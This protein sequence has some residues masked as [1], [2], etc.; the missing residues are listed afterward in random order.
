MLG[1]GENMWRR[2]GRFRSSI[3]SRYDENSAS[4]VCSKALANAFIEIYKP[5][6]CN[7]GLRLSRNPGGMHSTSS[8]C[9]RSTTRGSVVGEGVQQPQSIL[10]PCNLSRLSLLSNPVL[11][12][13]MPKRRQATLCALLRCPSYRAL[14]GCNCEHSVL[15]AYRAHMTLLKSTPCASNRRLGVDEHAA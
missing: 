4:R 14:S 3:N 11:Q 15:G 9:T 12:L 1:A 2:W 13:L 6:V 8:A 5:A 7:R 10:L